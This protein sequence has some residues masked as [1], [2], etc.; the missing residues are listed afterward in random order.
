M[1]HFHRG[2][3]T[4]GR[5]NHAV[6]RPV[7]IEVWLSE[8]SFLRIREDG[9]HAVCST[10]IRHQTMIRG[11]GAHLRARKNQLQ[12]FHNHLRDQY[13]DRVCY[14]EARGLSRLRSNTLVLVADGMD[15]SKFEIPRSSM[16]RGKEFATLQKI[17]MHVV[18]CIAHG[19]CCMF[20]VGLP[21]TK[22]DSNAS[23]EILAAMLTRL[24][25]KGLPLSQM[26]VHLQHDNTSREFKNN[27]GLRWAASQVS[28]KNLLSV[29][30]SY[31]RTGH[32]HE[33]IDQV[34]SRLSK[35]LGRVRDLQDPNDVCATIED[36][37]QRAHMPFE[38]DRVVVRMDNVRNW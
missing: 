26:H 22:K 15:Q 20:G 4:A 31:L 23:I 9:H 33:D 24:R 38:G 12:L 8:Y 14:W 5:L 27:G 18:A 32:T 2:R 16:T 21:D 11:L 25:D 19:H 1:L 17:R 6:A 29:T 34:F 3:V 13:N 28:S 37:L 7:L 35:H 30:C 10:C 36:F